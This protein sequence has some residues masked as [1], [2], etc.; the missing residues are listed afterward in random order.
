MITGICCPLNLLLLLSTITTNASRIYKNCNCFIAYSSA[1]RK[2]SSLRCR[3]RVCDSSKK[4]GFFIWGFSLLAVA[5]KKA[6][7]KIELHRSHWE[8]PTPHCTRHVCILFLPVYKIQSMIW[9]VISRS[10]WV[11]PIW[12]LFIY[13]NISWQHQQLSCFSWLINYGG[14]LC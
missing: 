5:T 11:K 10:S 6:D 2:V 7:H 13:A 8:F 1:L 9:R 3:H 4:E 14:R 12:Y